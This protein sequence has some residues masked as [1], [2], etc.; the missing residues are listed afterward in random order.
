MGIVVRHDDGRDQPLRRR[1]LRD[2]AGCSRA[3][4]R[5]GERRARRAA[6]RKWRTRGIRRSSTASQSGVGT[7]GGRTGCRGRP[8]N[9][10]R[11]VDSERRPI[12]HETLVWA[13]GATARA[14]HRAPRPD[15]RS[16]ASRWRRTRTPSGGRCRASGEDGAGVAEAEEIAA[17]ADALPLRRAARVD[18]AAA[19]LAER[20]AG[21]TTRAGTGTSP[22]MPKPFLALL[23]A[24]ALPVALSGQSPVP[25]P[26]PNPSP[27]PSPTDDRP[28]CLGFAF[29]RWTP[30][31]D[32]AAA[33]HAPVGG[34]I[35]QAPNGR[36][37]AAAI[38]AGRDTT[39]MLFP[40]WWPAGVHVRLP[41]RRASA[42]DTVRARPRPRRDGRCARRRRWCSCGPCAADAPGRS[43]RRRPKR[44]G[45]HDAH[46]RAPGEV[47]Q[48]HERDE[49]REGERERD[50]RVLPHEQHQC[51]HTPASA[52]FAMPFVTGSGEVSTA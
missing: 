49:Q 45:A 38:E 2:A 12:P 34:A 47:Q 14:A 42:V 30:A 51:R 13:R 4:R 22:P 50:P 17:I 41:A 40:S 3:E 6:V 31:L 20:A 52:T 48:Q 1:G 36:D 26:S 28:Q 10:R 19:A 16:L 39:L 15:R 35:P 43:G 29:G 46:E 5:R 32:A 25:A 37:W 11:C 21:A 18:R 9:S 24:A 33:G 27:N 44:R 8:R 7:S 23:V